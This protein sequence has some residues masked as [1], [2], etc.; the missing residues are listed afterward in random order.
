MK[1]PD[2]SRGATKFSFNP[3]CA[4]SSHEA[5]KFVACCCGYLTCFLRPHASSIEQTQGQDDDEELR[6]NFAS[7]HVAILLNLKPPC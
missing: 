2:L 4:I 5:G 6:N 3:S 1:N 7:R